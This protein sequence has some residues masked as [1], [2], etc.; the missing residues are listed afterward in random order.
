MVLPPVPHLPPQVLHVTIRVSYDG[1]HER[2]RPQR[3]H[4]HFA[5]LELGN[6]RPEPVRKSEVLAKNRYHQGDHVL[7][8]LKVA[9]HLVRSCQSDYAA[10]E[11][12]DSD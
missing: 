10:I 1:K 2:L 9:S 3:A 8:G 7:Q 11:A 4:N 5:L 6:L 12:G